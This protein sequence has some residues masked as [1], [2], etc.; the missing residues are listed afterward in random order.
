MGIVGEYGQQAIYVRVFGVLRV[1]ESPIARA[2]EPFSVAI[3]L[4]LSEQEMEVVYTRCD[5]SIWSS[6]RFVLAKH[7]WEEASF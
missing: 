1:N 2:T 3:S 4:L 7:V 6:V 5:N